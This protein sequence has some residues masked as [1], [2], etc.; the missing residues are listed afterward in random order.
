M[1]D[2]FTWAN[3]DNLAKS[4]EQER[5]ESYRKALANLPED[6]RGENGVQTFASQVYVP[7][8][9][10]IDTLPDGR[11]IIACAAG[12]PMP[13]AEARRRGLVTDV[14]GGV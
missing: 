11:C 3:D 6:Q 12:Q 14:E 5:H 7:Q 2:A 10:I 4:A 13:I 1:I 8:H 9:D